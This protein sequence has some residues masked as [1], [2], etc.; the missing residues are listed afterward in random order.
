MV[1][2]KYRIKCNTENSYVFKW[3]KNQPIV[4]PNNNT[5]TIDNT[6]IAIV[7]SIS[8]NELKVLN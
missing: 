7:D 5:H 6:S 1:L 8:E 3:D 2:H 4:C